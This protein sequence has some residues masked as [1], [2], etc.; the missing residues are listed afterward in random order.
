MSR[1]DD[2]SRHL[3]DVDA[4]LDDQPDRARRD[5]AVEVGVSRRRIGQRAAGGE[6]QLATLE[7]IGQVGEVADVDPP[8]RRIKRAVGDH[9]GLP[10]LH[11]RECEDVRDGW[12][13]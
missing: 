12:L 6:Y 7:Q 4:Q 10:G 1:L 9:F 8:D 3:V 2:R 13:H 5:Q 11:H